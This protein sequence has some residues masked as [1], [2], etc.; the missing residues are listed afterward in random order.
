MPN[1]DNF[2]ITTITPEI[3]NRLISRFNNFVYIISH[4]SSSE[5][6]YIAILRKEY[7]KDFSSLCSNL[8]KI[9]G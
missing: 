3:F 9:K 8:E 5:Y 7:W 4:Y 6:C 2:I 1:L